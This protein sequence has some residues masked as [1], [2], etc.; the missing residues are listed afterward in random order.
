M[1]GFGALVG[2]FVSGDVRA[3]PGA[4]TYYVSPSGRDT[5]DGSTKKT[6][7]RTLARAAQQQFNAG[8]RLL[9]EAGV[10]HSGSITPDPSNSAGNFEIGSYGGGSAIIDAGDHSGIV[11]KNLSDITISHLVIRGTAG[12]RKMTTC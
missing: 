8:D 3:V 6:A 12:R 10:V 1:I 7:W 9:L 4:Q 2:A 11:I 5:A